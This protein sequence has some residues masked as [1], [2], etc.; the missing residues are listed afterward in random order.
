MSISKSLIMTAASFFI[1]ANLVARPAPMPTEVTLEDF[2]NAALAFEAADNAFMSKPEGK[3]AML[4]KNNL[5]MNIYKSS[6]EGKDILK[7]VKESLALAGKGCSR[8]G[9]AKKVQPQKITKESRELAQKEVMKKVEGYLTKKV[10]K[11]DE[12]VAV[13]AKLFPIIKAS[14][15]YFTSLAKVYETMPEIYNQRSIASH[16]CK[17]T[18]Q[19]L[20][21]QGFTAEN[22]NQEMVNAGVQ[23]TLVLGKLTHW[24]KKM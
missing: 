9:A 23:N 18:A 15:D 4:H 22:L 14:K 3:M 2:K 7:I 10:K 21:N 16:E 11:A 17:R 12:N 5:R 20:L 8:C 6:R 24:A 19:A 1:A 13:E